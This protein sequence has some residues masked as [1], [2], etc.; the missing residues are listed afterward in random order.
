[1]PF[2][3]GI[4][5]VLPVFFKQNMGLP[6]LA[7]V[8]AGFLLLLVLELQRTRSL[9]GALHSEPA[10]ALAGMSI[11]LLVA[12]AA[13]AST[14]GLGNYLHWTVEFAARR[15][16][17]GLPQMLSVYREPSL[18]W[19]L[20]ALGAG[21][22][23]CYTRLMKRGWARIT[24]FGLMAAPFAGTVLLYFIQDD[25]DDRA[26]NL[27]ALWPM[28]LLAAVVVALVQLRRGIT[29][30]RLIPFFVL[31]AVHGAF[32]SQQLWGSTYAIWPLLLVLIAQT[33]AALPASARQ[34]VIALALVSGATFTVWGGLY[35][36]SL[37]RLSYIR[38][39]DAPIEHSSVPVLRGMADRGPY[40][41]NLDELLAFAAREIPPSDALLLLPGEDPFYYA[42]GR[43]PQFPVTL[44]DPTT[45]PYSA[46]ELL[47]QARRRK[48]RWVI[49][50]RVLQ[51]QED[52]MPERA[53]TMQLILEEY[54]LDRRLA[55]YDIYRR[56]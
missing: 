31:A 48:V 27:L 39:P 15:R 36:I 26:D 40:L 56:R 16:L 25:A 50:K 23:L 41:A 37:D 24:A 38:I 35:A 10:F 3:A 47:A 49:V 32:L 4:A 7:A 1:L 11:A 51:I 42:T 18:G 2:A 28:W 45:D 46:P 14:A 44:M 20:P 6:F 55:G 19:M 13:I 22:A 43:I 12:L 21:L 17:P 34:P 5:A 53:E 33:F 52:P 8:A 29:P 30:L 9:R 54:A